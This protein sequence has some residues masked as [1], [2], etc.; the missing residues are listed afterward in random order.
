MKN[1]AVRI[2]LVCLMNWDK[3]LYYIIGITFNKIADKNNKRTIFM[4]LFVIK[5]NRHSEIH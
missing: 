5:K 3:L 4:I 1:V 2:L